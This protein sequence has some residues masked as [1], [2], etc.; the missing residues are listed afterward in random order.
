VSALREAVLRKSRL[1]ATVKD[2]FFAEHADRVVACAEAI[3]AALAKGGK[4][5]AF[6]NGGSACDA[7]HLALEFLH[8]AVEKRAPLPACALSHDSALLSAIGNDHDFAFAFAEPLKLLA[9]PPDV[10]VALSTSGKSRNVLRGL[11]AARELG[12]LTVGLTGRDGG[13]MAEL[14]DHFFRVASFDIHRIQETHQTLIHILWDLVHVLRG[15][16]DI[17]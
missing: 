11:Q 10:V 8:P 12:L 6:G 3:D 4:L 9:K 17:S 16:E 14:S 2:A 13:R 7:Q 1:S 15:E 5:I